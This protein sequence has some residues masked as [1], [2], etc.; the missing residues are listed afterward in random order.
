MHMDGVWKV[1][2]AAE[3]KACLRMLMAESAS[4]DQD[5]HLGL[6]WRRDVSGLMMELKWQMKRDRS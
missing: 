6:P 1:S 3:L 2:P 5:K 4:G